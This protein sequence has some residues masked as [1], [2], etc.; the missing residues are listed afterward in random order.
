MSLQ[1]GP[2]CT[3]HT[4]PWDSQSKFSKYLSAKN[5]HGV[6]LGSTERAANRVNGKA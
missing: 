5:A 3:L 4:S 2:L 6:V 1:M